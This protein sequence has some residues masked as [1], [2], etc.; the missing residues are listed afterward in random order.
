MRPIIAS[1]KHIVQIPINT[2]IG[3]TIEN[4]I[5]ARSKQDYQSSVADNVE[6]GT[7]VKA[8]YVELWAQSDGQNIGSVTITV[9]KLPGAAALMTTVDSAAL[10]GYLNKNNVF[11]TTQG[12]TGENDT[13]PIPFL[14]MWIKIP[15]GKQR[16][17]INERLVLNLS[18]NLQNTI[19]CGLVIFKSYT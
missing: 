19:H 8:V 15:K 11:Y 18:S 10:H 7:I 2:T 12:L 5:F 6:V 1:R 3:G 17:A 9:E 16:L 13:N 4:I 14:R